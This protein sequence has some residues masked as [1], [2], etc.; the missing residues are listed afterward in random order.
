[1]YVLPCVCVRVCS[2]FPEIAFF[3]L[4][5]LVAYITRIKDNAFGCIVP[6][7]SVCYT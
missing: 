1:M 3:N 2:I 5:F 6:R 4:M 7:Y